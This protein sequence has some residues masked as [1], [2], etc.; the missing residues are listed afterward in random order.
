MSLNKRRVC[1]TPWP[2]EA[3]RHLSPFARMEQRLRVARLAGINGDAQLRA[4]AEVEAARARVGYAL[5]AKLLP[6]SI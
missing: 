4:R 2:K 6:K 1:G 5:L 3:D